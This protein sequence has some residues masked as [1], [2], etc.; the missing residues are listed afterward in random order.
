MEMTPSQHEAYGKLRSLVKTIQRNTNHHLKFI[1]V[2]REVARALGVPEHSQTIT[3]GGIEIHVREQ[4]DLKVPIARIN[5]EQWAEIRES[6]DRVTQ[7]MLIVNNESIAEVIR[8][9]DR[10]DAQV[11]QLRADMA[12]ME[13][14]IKDLTTRLRAIRNNNIRA[15]EHLDKAFE[16]PEDARS[17]GLAGAVAY[18]TACYA[19]AMR[20]IA[21]AV[22]QSEIVVKV[23]KEADPSVQ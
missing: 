1:A 10:L 20:Q 11:A 7:P 2:E 23:V 9:R 5:S 19:A 17:A 13:E 18:A 8:E 12:P 6:L 22:P 4:E 3:L 14:Q 21:G 15:R 16:I